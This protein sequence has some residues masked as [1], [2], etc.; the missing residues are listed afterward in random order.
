[1]AAAVHL[2]H[3]PLGTHRGCAR[4]SSQIAASIAAGTCQGC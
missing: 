1:M 2:E 4:R 3:Q